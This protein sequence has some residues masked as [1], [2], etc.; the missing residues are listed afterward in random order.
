MTQNWGAAKRNEFQE[1]KSEKEKEPRC[2]LSDHCIRMWQKL[3]G[4]EFAKTTCK[5]YWVQ[6]P[7]TEIRSHNQGPESTAPRRM[8]YAIY[9]YCPTAYAVLHM[10][11]TSIVVVRILR[12]LVHISFISY[13]KWAVLGVYAYFY[14]HTVVLP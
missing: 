10:Q 3:S 2:S 9:E 12:V 5:T 8:Q 13:K 11:Y 4:M 1:S 6:V 7:K 14:V